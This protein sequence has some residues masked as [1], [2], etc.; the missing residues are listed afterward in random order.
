MSD[1]VIL[2]TQAKARHRERAR[3]NARALAGAGVDE[4]ELLDAMNKVH[5]AVLEQP[6]AGGG[7]DIHLGL[8]QYGRGVPFCTAAVGAKVWAREALGAFRSPYFSMRLPENQRWWCGIAWLELNRG[9]PT[10]IDY[11]YRYARDQGFKQPTRLG[12][13]LERDEGPRLGREG[14]TRGS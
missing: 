3:A 9:C 6:L 8:A 1:A 5:L 14:F 4:D 10:C 2:R 11:A 12:E 7:L 13:L